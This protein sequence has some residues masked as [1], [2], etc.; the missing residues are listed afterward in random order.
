[1]NRTLRTV[2]NNAGKNLQFT[3]LLR[4]CKDG[5]TGYSCSRRLCRFYDELAF[6]MRQRRISSL[7]KVLSMAPPEKTDRK[8]IPSGS[9][10]DET[11]LKIAKEISI[12]FIEVGRITPATFEQ[13]FKHIYSAIDTT[14]KRG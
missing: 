3:V 6:F 5:L 4:A 2:D 9:V 13:S 8:N 1:M 12:K 7:T 11:I 10:T 14:V